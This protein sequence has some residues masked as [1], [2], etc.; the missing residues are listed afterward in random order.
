MV[1]DKLICLIDKDGKILITPFM[2]GWGCPIGSK[3]HF[4]DNL[5]EVTN[6]VELGEDRLIVT[7]K[8]ITKEI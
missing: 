2:S 5:Y 4:N 3:T 8:K 1:T 6:R 7:V